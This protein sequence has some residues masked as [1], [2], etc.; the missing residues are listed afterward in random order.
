MSALPSFASVRYIDRWGANPAGE[1]FSGVAV[2]V[3]NTDEAPPKYVLAAR[4]MEGEKPVAYS[5]KGAGAVGSVGVRPP[6]PLAGGS[7]SVQVQWCEPS[8]EPAALPWIEGSLSAAP[9]ITT[10]LELTGGSVVTASDSVAMTLGWEAH[11]GAPPDCVEVQLVTARGPL[12]PQTVEGATAKIDLPEAPATGYL[13]YLAA[14]ANLGTDS[15]GKTAYSVG[16]FSQA[17]QIP[18]AAPDVTKV[19]YD[20]THLHATWTAPS[21]ATA[22]PVA[23]ERQSLVVLSD[24]KPI[25]AFPAAAGAGTAAIDLSAD[26]A[27]TVA[28]VTSYGAVDGPP[29]K[30][31]TVLTQAPAIS[32]VTTTTAQGEATLAVD[33]ARAA[34]GG[35]SILVELLEEGVSVATATATPGGSGAAAS[36]GYALKP[37][38][39]YALVARE[40]LTAGKVTIATGPPSPGMPLV[41][42]QPTG[43]TAAYDGER[44]DLGWSAGSGAEPPGYSPLTGH[45]VVLTGSLSG[46]FA[47]GPEPG[48]SLPASL[49]PGDRVS[50]EVTPLAGVAGGIAASLSYTVPAPAAP[51]ITGIAVDGEEVTV[52]WSPSTGPWL[53][54]YTVTATASS[55]EGTAPAATTCTG[56]ETT[57]TFRLPPQETASAWTLSVVATAR[58]KAGAPSAPVELFP[59][60]ALIESV[61]TDGSSATVKWMLEPWSSTV[62]AALGQ[63]KL[64]V[65]ILDDGNVVAVKGVTPEAASASTTVS[66]PAPRTG[67]LGAAVQ[68]VGDQQTGARSGAVPVL[69]DAPSILFGALAEDSLELWWSPSGDAGLSG[70]EVCCGSACANTAEAE[71]ALPLRGATPTEVS[72]RALGPG[73][74]GPAVKQAIVGSYDIASGSY[75][76]GT[77]TVKFAAASAA[78]SEQVRVDVLLGEEVVG[79][80]L[81]AGTVTTATIAVLLPPGSPARVRA[82]GVGK[83]S[84]TTAGAPWAVPTSTPGNVR[85]V[86]DGTDAHVQWDPVSDS[87][88]TGYLIAVA[89]AQPAVEQYVAGAASAEAKLAA[90]LPAPFPGAATVSVRAVVAPDPEHTGEQERLTGPVSTAAVP[91]LAGSVRAV[92]A[93]AAAGDQPQ[94]P[95][96]YRRGAYAA[97]SDVHE[98]AVE[99]LLASP[100]A[101]G[102]PTVQ[103]QAGTFKLAPS[104][105]A[106]G[107]AYALT[108]AASAWTFDG[109]AA[110]AALRSS[111]REFLTKLDEAGAVPGGVGLV[112]EAVAAALPQ[113]FAETLYYR[114]GVWHGSASRVVD[115]EAG[116]RLRVSGADYQTPTGTSDRHSGYVTVGADTYDLGQ[117][118]PAG[119]DQAGLAP[120]LTV[121]A[122]LSQLFPG[123]SGGSQGTI[124]AGPVDFFGVGARQAYFRLF[125]PKAFEASEA[126]GPLKLVENIA[127]LGAP[128]WKLLEEATTAYETTSAFPTQT[129]LF[130]AYFRGRATL[131]PLVEVTVNGRS[132][133]VPLGTSLRDLLAAEGSPALG[134]AA[135]AAA[136]GVSLS[137]VIAN[138]YDSALGG[139]PLR[140]DRV[141]LSGAGMTATPA[142]WPLDLPVLGGDELGVAAWEPPIAGPP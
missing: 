66:L 45:Q 120:A 65:Q 98:K 84:L 21:P 33:L 25:A 96:L 100:F 77:L 27:I 70:Y 80:A 127:V 9:V 138:V 34:S 126:P 125:F 51:T 42:T 130:T 13:L 58:G 141:D 5:K 92:N 28:G 102:T 14:K 95:Y 61:S 105:S 1:S 20:G 107:P 90:A 24:G 133:W 30:A 48:I 75:A 43:L 55:G 135:P 114:Y 97:F 38:C 121:D 109:N 3:A 56:P 32:K 44:L 142:L 85:A 116:M 57:A 4:L 54:G 11:G 123:G 104:G 68:L 41:T 16:P 91:A 15:R 137:R 128:S 49:E 101:Q 63:A 64:Q 93:P 131:T 73:S 35:A 50:F 23:E 59:T 47:T 12:E 82:T 86:Y 36:L 94:P 103:D 122:F 83:G 52:N 139:A 140:R 10:A 134:A 72:V 6:A 8:K 39:S 99:I 110:R 26:P 87:G 81:V 117:V 79:S 2:T 132:R 29:G 136:P 129:N 31:A 108:I 71:I 74:A 124:A 89:G 22:P 7:F 118:F 46:T 113:T 88:V 19:D 67:R 115:L 17:R 112:R 76:D 69:A 119:A 106:T 111:Y 62:Q 18:I 40:T 78:A 53:D 37:Q 60:T